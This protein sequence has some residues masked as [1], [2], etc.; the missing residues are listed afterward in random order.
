MRSGSIRPL[1][2]QSNDWDR[3]GPIGRGA[4]SITTLPAFRAGGPISGPFT[5]EL[6]VEAAQTMGRGSLSIRWPKSP[7]P[8]SRA[9]FAA[10]KMEVSRLAGAIRLPSPFMV[11]SGSGPRVRGC[12]GGA[13][14]HL[15]GLSRRLCP[16]TPSGP[17]PPTMG[18][19][20]EPVLDG[21]QYPLKVA[22]S[23]GSQVHRRSRA[24]REWGGPPT[25]LYL[26][27]TASSLLTALRPYRYS[28]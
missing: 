1:Q 17:F 19:D 5:R 7:R 8:E 27:R 18:R 4:S 24:F 25:P 14:S 16:A 23:S 21:R 26:R 20:A 13:T 6:S 12:P 10:H 15:L 22:A 2:Q 9:S 28:L 3:L 11:T